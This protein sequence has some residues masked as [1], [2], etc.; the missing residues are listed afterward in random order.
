MKQ[1]ENEIPFAIK[2]MLHAH[3]AFCELTD[4]RRR[5]ERS[6][7]SYPENLSTCEDKACELVESIIKLSRSTSINASR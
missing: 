2:A 3:Y 6:Q 5:L 4:E 7:G 1:G